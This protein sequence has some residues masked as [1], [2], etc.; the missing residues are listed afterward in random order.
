MIKKY[1]IQ[2]E[3]AKAIYKFSYG[4]LTVKQA[5]IRAEAV[6]KNFDETNEGLG[7]KGINWY[8]KQI[9]RAEVVNNE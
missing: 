9:L 3:L 7:H 2:D 4:R 6:M 5:E 1:S 8:A